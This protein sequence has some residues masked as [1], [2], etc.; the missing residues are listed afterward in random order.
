M[1]LFNIV[2]SFGLDYFDDLKMNWIT[3]QAIEIMNS[4]QRISCGRIDRMKATAMMT[5]IKTTNQTE[6]LK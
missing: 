4:I 6:F 1:Q 5:K 2:F 3:I